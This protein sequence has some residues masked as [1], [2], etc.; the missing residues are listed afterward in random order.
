MGKTITILNASEQTKTVAA[1]KKAQRKAKGK[2]KAYIQDLLEGLGAK[3]NPT[4]RTR[5]RKEAPAMAKR[6]KTAR[7]RAPKTNPS[8][9]SFKRTSKRRRSNPSTS[10]KKPDIMGVLMDG[11]ATAAGALGV[12]FV[13]RQVKRF[14]PDTNPAITSGIATVAVA[15]GLVFFGGGSSVVRSL[16]VGAVAGGLQNLAQSLMPSLFA[17]DE[18][19]QGAYDY[20]GLEGWNAD[21]TWNNELGEAEEMGEAD[22][23][24]GVLYERGSIPSTRSFR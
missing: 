8:F 1:L 16:A 24:S 11:A 20:A 6:K 17:G 9:P 10:G 15:G 23:L 12:S 7:K 2:A 21:G 19:Y 4:G 3:P 14:M 18:D 13:D 5:D 22:E